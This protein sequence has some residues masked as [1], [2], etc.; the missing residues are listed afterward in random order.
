MSKKKRDFHNKRKH[1]VVTGYCGVSIHA[2]IFEQKRT[3][4]PR[5]FFVHH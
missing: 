2:L 3:R 1:M 4:V 5:P